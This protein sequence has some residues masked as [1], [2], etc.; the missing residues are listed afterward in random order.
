MSG[1]KYLKENLPRMLNEILLQK[2][3]NKDYV[4]KIKIKK[5]SFQQTCLARNTKSNWKRKLHRSETQSYVKESVREGIHKGKIKYFIF[6]LLIELQLNL[7]I[8]AMMYLGF[9]NL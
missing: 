1:V 6:L 8:I 9:N 7:L 4:R 2:W 3:R 5:I